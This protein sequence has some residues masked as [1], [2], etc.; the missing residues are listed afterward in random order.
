MLSSCRRRRHPAKKTLT[1]LVYRFKGK[2]SPFNCIPC[3]FILCCCWGFKSIL[4]CDFISDMVSS[5]TLECKINRL[6]EVHYWIKINCF[7]SGACRTFFFLS[8]FLI[9]CVGI[10][11][12]HPTLFHTPRVLFLSP[13]VTSKFICTRASEW[14]YQ[15]NQKIN[16]ISTNGWRVSERNKMVL[17]SFLPLH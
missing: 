3:L 5:L 2:K 12:L 10:F 1:F 8:L 17:F 6:S 9:L 16:N 13:K 15:Q 4:A 11:H 7:F 14:D